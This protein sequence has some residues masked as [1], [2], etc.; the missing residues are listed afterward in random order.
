MA[1]RVKLAANLS[2]LF[3]DRQFLDRF[4]AA[5]ACGFTAVEFGPYV[6]AEW[7]REELVAAAERAGVEVV[8]ICTP[9]SCASDRGV[10]AIPGKEADFEAL[11][12]KTIDYA[13]ALKCSR[14]HPLAGILPEAK[15]KN[16]L[17][18]SHA[19]TTYVANLRRAA[20]ECSK[21]SLTVLIEPISTIPNYFLQ[22]QKE[23]VDIIRDAGQ[24][25]IKIEFDVFHAQ[26]LDGNLSVFLRD[27][28]SL[29]GHVQIAQLP[30][31]DEPD[32]NGEVNFPFLFKLLNKLGYDGWVACEYVPRGRTEDGL[33]WATPYLKCTSSASV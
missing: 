21:H 27:N 25:N 19:R 30:G 4:D 14:I 17:L 16:E 29:V 3:Q 31:R 7:S 13:L 26:T 28:I 9:V 1:A 6:I 22:H 23:A 20:E 33:G 2:F 15:E 12:A 18:W 11:L 5:A 10:A 32:D 24:Q 8:S